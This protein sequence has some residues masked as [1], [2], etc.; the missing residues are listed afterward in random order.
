[1]RI[2]ILLFF[3]TTLQLRGQSKLNKPA[4]ELEFLKILNSTVT[5]AKLSDFK[6]KVVILDFWGTW[7]APCIEALPHL[8]NLQNR[9]G[10]DL[11]VITITDESEERIDKFLKKRNVSL[12]IA[13]DNDRKL[14]AAFPYR[15][16]SHT[17]VIDKNGIVRAITTPQEIN[18]EILKQIIAG[19][20]VDLPEKVDNINFD[21]SKPLSVN[22]NFTYQITVTPFQNGLPSMSNPTGGNGVYK[23]RRI[24]CTNLSP[25]SLYEV[26][27]NI[28]LA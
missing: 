11:K 7:C 18:E 12:P 25:K 26:A 20:Q 19:Q 23:G 10:N 28:Q 27:S 15:A 9:F 14:A 24:L 3:L 21:P 5:S 1:M 4:G 2:I 13:L 8:E 16:V 22:V 6:S 17:V